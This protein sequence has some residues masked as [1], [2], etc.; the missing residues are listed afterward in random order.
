M[1]YFGNI[2]LKISI[3]FLLIL[4]SSCEKALMDSVPETDSFAI[5]D[6]YSKL[7]KEKYAMLEF[8]DVD[9]TSLENSLRS[10]ITD[11]T[12]ENELFEIIGQI[13]LSLRDGHSSL[14][15]NIADPTIAAQFDFLEGYSP[16]IDLEILNGYVDTLN[17][18]YVGES[19]IVRLVWGVLP[20][21]NS[22]GYIWVPS[23]NREIS[24]SEI[25]Q[26]FSDLK[27]TKGLIFDQRMNT[28]GDPIL[29]T[30]FASYFIDEPLYTG[31]ERFKTGPEMN[32]FSDSHFTLQ[33]SRNP[34]TYL[35]PVM[36][37]TDRNV[38]SAATTFLYSLDP[39]ERVKTVGQ[40]T[41]GGSGSVADGF[42]ANGWY[43]SLSTSE[44]I[45]ANGRHLDDGVEPDIPVVL[46]L[47]DKTKDEV[48]ERAI[49]ELVK[50]F[51]N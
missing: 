32:D 13:T 37:L 7:V 2:Q 40:I 16:G 3:L 4:F 26:V 43:W 15:D 1:K 41:G 18:L 31:F 34:N 19:D 44:F 39:L 50:S 51:K 28:G 48:I 45:D 6:E 20:Q 17:K 30:K 35:K 33:P 22:I 29:A 9:I 5:F 25:E 38:Y 49:M 27:E 24:D 36:A 8:K 47:D 23:W 42:L 46:N 11:Q 14:V 21:N 12:T 10:Q